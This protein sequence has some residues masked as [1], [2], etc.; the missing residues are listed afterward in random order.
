MAGWGILSGEKGY[1]I[2]PD[3]IDIRVNPIGDVLEQHL[4]VAKLFSEARNAD[5]SV[6][7]AVAITETEKDTGHSLQEY[8]KLLSPVDI[9]DI[10]YLTP[11]HLAEVCGFKSNQRVN[12]VLEKTWEGLVCH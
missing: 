11:T 8:Q 7:V 12:K 5:Y 1:C 3:K 10:G 6:M 4:K 2:S 9:P